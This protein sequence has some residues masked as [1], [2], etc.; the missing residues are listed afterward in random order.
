[1]GI[2]DR[3]YDNVLIREDGTLFHIDF[4]F[5]LGFDFLLSSTQLPREPLEKTTEPKLDTV[6]TQPISL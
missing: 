3:H 1:M 5:I 6:P 4:G 2:G